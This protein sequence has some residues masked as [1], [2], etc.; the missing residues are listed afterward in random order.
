MATAPATGELYREHAPAAR[1]T[2]LA[3]VPADAADDIV[4]EAFT[5]VIAAR[6]RGAGPAEFRP[7]LL[8][9]V[10]NAARDWNARRWRAVPVPDP[11]PLGTYPAADE[12]AVGKDEAGRVIAA[13]GSLPPRWQQVLWQTEVEGR[14]PAELARE[15]GMSAN[16]V[17]AL[18]LRA[19]E[20]LAEAW[21]QQHAGRAARG[22]QPYAALL[23]AATRGK[24]PRGARQRLET[25][26]ERC[27]ACAQARGELARLNTALRS[28]LAPAAVITAASRRSP[29]PRRTLTAV[30]LGAVAFTVLALVPPHVSDLP[31]VVLP[32]P[33][34]VPRVTLVPAPSPPPH[35]AE[36]F[37]PAAATAPASSTLAAPPVTASTGKPLVTAKAGPAPAASPAKSAP[38]PHPSS[39][40][41][42]VTPSP[43]Q[44]P[45]PAT[46]PA[47]PAPAT[48]PA[49]APPPATTAPATPEPVPVPTGTPPPGY[50]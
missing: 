11:E 17:S 36:T 41:P 44:T 27:P 9:A 48:S 50:F 32:S 46:S 15:S 31:S 42:T 18:A 38:A 4:S 2:A 29:W 5:R 13:F 26:L 22:C 10:R 34:P 12:L 7:Y 19:R 37:R 1:R 3:M 16:A 33:S 47:S 6:R 43:S 28:V 40:A 8:A 21:L 14:K 24:L 23:G 25:H 49:A 30:S 20:G 39:P 45:A 35:P